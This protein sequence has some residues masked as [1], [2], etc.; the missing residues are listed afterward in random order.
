LHGW[1]Q[2]S[3]L[4]VGYMDTGNWAT[5]IA[6]WMFKDEYDLALA[7]MDGSSEC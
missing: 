4:A 2:R 1:Q 6:G 7:I 5:D 3:L